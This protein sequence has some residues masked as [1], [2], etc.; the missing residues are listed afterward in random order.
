MYYTY[1]LYSEKFDR[2]YVGHCEDLIKRLDRHNRKMVPSTKNYTPWILAYSESY[3]TRQE[4]NA[5]ELYI[6]SMKSRKFI[7]SLINKK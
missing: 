3:P 4:A 1:I 2:Y 6:K 5:R 7:E